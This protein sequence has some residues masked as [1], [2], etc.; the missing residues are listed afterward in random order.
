MR[1]RRIAPLAAR[2][3]RRGDGQARPATDRTRSLGQSMVEFAL[4]L[5]IMLLLVGAAVDLGRLFFAYVAV[6][7][8]AKEG[9][10]YGARH[11]LCADSTNVNCDTAG[12]NVTWYV[13][14]E[15]ATGLKTALGASNLTT[16]VT[17]RAKTTGALRQPI[18][19]CVNGDTYEV[20]VSYG[21]R[22]VT[23]IISSILG[24]TITLSSQSTA[25][26]IG[27]GFDPAGLEI[28][29][30]VDSSNADNVSTISTAC[31]LADSAVAP[32]Y[33][34]APCQ[35][36]S[37]VDNY[38]QFKEGATVTYKLRVKNTGNIDLT[39]I[40]YQ[41]SMNGTNVSTPA[42]CSTLPTSIL[43]SAGATYCTFTQTV[44]A[45]TVGSLND[46]KIGLQASANA[47]GLSTGTN[48]VA[49]IVK[50]IPRPRLAV[51]VWASPYRLGG[52]GNGLSG[53]ASYGAGGLTLNLDAVAAD[54]TMRE[55]AA[56]LYIQ[57]QNQGG[58]ASNLTFNLTRNAA[59]VSLSSCTIPTSLATY[60][61]TGDSFMCLVPVSF[62]AVG[63]YAFAGTASATN[64]VTVSGT[65]PNVTVTVATCSGGLK[66]VPNLV[67][68]LS[69]TPDGT[70]KT[71]SQAKNAWQTEGFDGN[72][73]TSSPAGASGSAKVTSQ[74]VTAYSCAAITS[75]VVVATP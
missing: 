27:D 42:A 40:A 61:T 28:L 44:T 58:T 72:N 11:P 71:F 9:V 16:G 5:P 68:T 13:E 24:T 74:S 67:D 35:S 6:E 59:P 32:G 33:Y 75:P 57:V 48:N 26:V 60:G 53:V 65:Q 46:F 25:T 10:M 39:N 45:T 2:L 38:L 64:S 1:L 49:A 4:I 41:F 51:N 69:P 37:N 55:P 7:N 23:P 52:T 47:A 14:N 3:R 63:S 12:Q 54:Q 70:N 18:N 50:V 19:D 22:M 62:S 21:F 8:A 73:I 36:L 15:A 17:C 43:K 66:P 29:L 31:Q 56:W 34:Y 20:R 30:W